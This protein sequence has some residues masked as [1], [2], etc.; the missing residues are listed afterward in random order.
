MPLDTCAYLVRDLAEGLAEGA[1]AGDESVVYDAGDGK[2][3][4]AAVLDLNQLLARELVALAEAKGVKLEVA[5]DGAGVVD[6]LIMAGQ[7]ASIS[8][9]PTHNRI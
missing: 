7:P 8:I 2:H 9:R 5:G 6:T 4:Q 3:S 1:L